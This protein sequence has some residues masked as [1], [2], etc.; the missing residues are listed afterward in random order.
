MPGRADNP[1]RRI[2]NYASKHFLADKPVIYAL[3]VSKRRQ[4]RQ[5]RRHKS[6]CEYMYMI[7]SDVIIITRW[8]DVPPPAI[9]LRAVFLSVTTIPCQCVSI[10]ILPMANT[11]M[12]KPGPPNTYS[13]LLWQ[14]QAFMRVMRFLRKLSS[15]LVVCVC[16]GL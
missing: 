10:L 6:D 15:C 7:H 16:R 13:I 12:H 3:T 8:S 11:E 2:L 5:D 1:L 4:E 9:W 14:N